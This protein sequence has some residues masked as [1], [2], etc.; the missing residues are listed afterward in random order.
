MTL[1]LAVSCALLII[2]YQELLGNYDI[3]KACEYIRAIIPYQE[4][5][6][7]YDLYNGTLTGDKIIPYQELLGNYDCAWGGRSAH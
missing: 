3:N 4:L 5:L 1:L 2:P 7:N 6:G